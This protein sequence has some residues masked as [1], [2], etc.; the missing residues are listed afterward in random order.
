LLA[1]FLHWEWVMHIAIVTTSCH[2]GFLP[3][4]SQPVYARICGEELTFLLVGRAGEGDLVLLFRKHAAEVTWSDLGCC[5]ARGFP[6][7]HMHLLPTSW[8]TWGYINQP[9]FSLLNRVI[10]N[11]TLHAG[12]PPNKF[13]H[14]GINSFKV[15]ENHSQL[16]YG[17]SQQNRFVVSIHISILLA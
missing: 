10:K 3:V 13:P 5:S 6:A 11:A 15:F 12:I 14:Q 9:I 16:V 7:C 2:W 1:W 17:A 4:W 8:P